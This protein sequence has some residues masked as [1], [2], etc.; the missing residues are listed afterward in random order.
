MG[1][2]KW[3]RQRGQTWGLLLFICT[4]EP[5]TA[6]ERNSFFSRFNKVENSWFCHCLF[7]VGGA[8]QW[9]R[10]KHCFM[11]SG[12]LHVQRNTSLWICFAYNSF[13]FFFFLTNPVVS[14]KY[15]VCVLF[16]L[17]LALQNTAAR[18]PVC[19]WGLI[20]TKCSE[21]QFSSSSRASHTTFKVSVCKTHCCF[22]LF[23]YF[24]NVMCIQQDKQLKGNI[25]SPT[26]SIT[27]L[28]C[29]P[30]LWRSGYRITPWLGG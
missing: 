15:C 3:C 1:G 28:A 8:W 20:Q 9:E 12:P 16:I 5:T 24:L 26:E 2:R 18:V 7:P 27:C 4:T 10:W 29:V 19:V 23:L 6:G 17:W 21:I 14:L 25:V 13:R 30:Y 11:M 22:Y